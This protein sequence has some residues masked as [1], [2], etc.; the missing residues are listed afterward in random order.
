MIETIR[1][2]LSTIV[3]EAHIW[4]LNVPWLAWQSVFAFYTLSGYLMTRVLNERYG[5]SWRGTAAFA[6]N[7]IL[8]LWPAYLV[9]ATLSYVTLRLHLMSPTYGLLRLPATAIETI[10]NITILGQVTFDYQFMAHL[11]VL[12]P[13]GWSLS[14]ELFCYLLLAL[15][16]AVTPAGL[17]WLAAIGAVALTL[18]TVYCVNSSGDYGPYCFQNRYGVLQAGF[19]PFALGGL[20]F[21]H[22]ARLKPAID[23]WAPTIAAAV[24]ASLFVIYRVPALQFTIAPFVGAFG[25]AALLIYSFGRDFHNSVTEFLGRASYHLFISHW[26]LA[27]ILI[28][29]TGMRPGSLA[30]MLCTLALAL[31][32]SCALV[33]MEHR[34]ERWRR[35]IASRAKSRQI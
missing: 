33:P 18:S 25:M 10:T 30:L 7:R 1:F 11:S 4:P 5:F 16:F 20:I 17:R 29:L 24:L 12:V 14:I 15:Y 23:K 31:L 8:R 9:V 3:L 22:G 32:L 6:A 2:F 21:F 27:A 13:N 35:Q 19:I 28:K 34:I 26:V